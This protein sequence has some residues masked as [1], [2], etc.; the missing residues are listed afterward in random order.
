MTKP[1]APSVLI[2]EPL[3][4]YKKEDSV[5]PEPSTNHIKPFGSDVKGKVDMGRKYV[6][7]Y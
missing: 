2:K 1:K 7:K 3:N 6:T 5:K 4:L